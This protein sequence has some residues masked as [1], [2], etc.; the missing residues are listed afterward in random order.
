MPYSIE[1]R[2]DEDTENHIKQIWSKAADYYDSDYVSTN[3]IIPHVALIVSKDDL[4]PVYDQMKIT[5][6][7]LEMDKVDFFDSGKI[8]YYNAVK[9]KPLKNL[10]DTCYSLAKRLGLSVD[11]Y[12]SPSRWIPHCTI[13]QHCVT[14]VGIIM[15]DIT[16]LIAASRSLIL[17]SYPPT[18]LVCEKNY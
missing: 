4:L 6:I 8:V 5:K 12:Y 18:I 10:H 9:S 17:M 14:N 16:P 3:G 15:P 2:F 11:P 1:I 7:K 13:S